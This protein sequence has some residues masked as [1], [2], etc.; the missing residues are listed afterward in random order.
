[1]LI[2]FYLVHYNFGAV[3]LLMTLLLVFL[4]MKKN[5]K[6][7]IV[8]IVALIAFNVAIYNKTANKTWTREFYRTDEVENRAFAALAPLNEAGYIKADESCQTPTEG[9][10]AA[11]DC[12]TKAWRQV[13][14]AIADG[15][16]AALNA[17][18]WLDR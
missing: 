8:F 9:V 12:R 10:F 3:A 18:R 15:A 11:G 4:L 14:T 7:A 17:C 16:A 1:M 13:A 6:L 5:Y 2:D